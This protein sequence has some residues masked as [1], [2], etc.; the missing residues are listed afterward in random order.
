MNPI[1]FSVYTIMI[2]FSLSSCY[3]RNEA[4]LDTIAT[5]YDVTADDDCDACCIYPTMSLNVSHMA[6]DSVFSPQKMYTNDLGQN[7][8]L[9]DVRFYLSAF[10][11]YQS[12]KGAQKTQIIA[13][14]YNSDKT[15]IIPDDMKICR[16]ADNTINIGSVKTYGRMDSLVFN[17]GLNDKITKNEFVDLPTSHV[18]LN[19]NKLKDENN[20]LAFASVRYV[21]FKPQKDTLNIFFRDLDVHSKIK[22]DSIITTSKGDHVRYTIKTD[23][24]KLFNNVNL[25][26]SLAVIEKQVSRNFERIIVVK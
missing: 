5:N 22:I 17:I 12:D 15:V 8:Q 13:S 9:L 23:Y 21:K 14:I 11:L 16:I 10:D 26:S 3:T 25:D 2:I 18:L 24:L 1:I 6:G 19:N 7:Y 20:N 4:C